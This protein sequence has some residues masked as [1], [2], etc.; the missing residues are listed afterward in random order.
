I[1]SRM[2]IVIATDKGLAGA[3]DANVLKLYARQLLDDDAAGIKNQTIA[4]GRR[5]NRF[6]SRLK[7]TQVTAA[8]QDLPDDPAGNQLR[9]IVDAAVESFENGDVDA[10]DIVFTEFVSTVKQEATVQ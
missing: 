8:Y 3:Y 9:A 7:D 6:V 4:V 10:V 2:L 1:K 5:A